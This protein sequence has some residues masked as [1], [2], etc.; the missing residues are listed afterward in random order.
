MKQPYPELTETVDRVAGVIK[1]GE[2]EFL[3]TLDAGLARIDRIFT[4][5]RKDGKTVIAGEA[6]AELY[7][8]FGVPPELTET[9]GAENGMTFDWEGFRHSMEQHARDSGEGGFEL[10]K[11]GPIE[12]LKS[13]LRETEFL[14]YETLAAEAEVKGIVLGDETVNDLESATAAGQDVIVVLDRSPFYGE[15]GGQVG[16]SGVLEA[17]GF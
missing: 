4:D 9:M 14:G 5:M 8:T 6:A 12:G 17:T 2:E 13:A 3:A 15:S 16:D 11:T 1:H 7:Q 10:F